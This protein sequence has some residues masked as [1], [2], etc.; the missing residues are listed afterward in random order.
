MKPLDPKIFDKLAEAQKAP[1]KIE[2]EIHDRISYIFDTIYKT[3]GKKYDTWYFYGAKKGEVGDLDDGF[4]NEWVNA[5]VVAQNNQYLIVILKDPDYGEE[6]ENLRH[7]F[8]E[9]WLY[10][11]FEAELVAGKKAWEQKQEAKK[12]QAQKSKEAKKAK[13]EADKKL[14]TRDQKETLRGRI[15]G[16]AGC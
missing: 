15:E 9:R 7:R 16:T 2:E 11:D 8:P 14:L 4:D 5:I 12:T 3:F 6:E 10:Q 13:Q 1:S